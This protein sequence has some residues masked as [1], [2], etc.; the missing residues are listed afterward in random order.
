VQS[1]LPVADIRERMRKARQGD[2]ELG[3]DALCGVFGREEQV[4]VRAK[5]ERRPLAR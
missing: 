3:G 2:L 5:P 4:F 1:H